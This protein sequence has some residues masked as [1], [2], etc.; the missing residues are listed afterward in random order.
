MAAVMGYT[1]LVTSWA[2]TAN[3]RLISGGSG[4]SPATFTLTPSAD[5][6]DSTVMAAS[7]LATSNLKGLRSWSAAI[8]AICPV[9]KIG[10]GASITFSPGY[11]A[12]CTTFD[13]SFSADSGDSTIM[14][15]SATTAGWKQNMPGLIS[16]EGSYEVLVDDTTALA[17]PAGSSEPATMTLTLATGLSF[18]GS[19][20][21][22]GGAITVNPRQRSTAKYAFK[23]S[24][25]VT[26][27]GTS[28]PFAAGSS[29]ALPAVGSIVLQAYTSRTFT[30]DCFW[31]QIKM[32]CPVGN[33][34][35]TSINA[36]GTGV[37]TPA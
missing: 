28:L 4:A 27:T 8:E 36:I 1:G 34:I 3:T 10:S 13:I 16:W 37:L 33:Q 2:G 25:N 11:V 23:G 29:I 22:T 12:N 6:F 31:N 24:G 14:G 19:V 18:A 5:A 32:S 15:A 21:T 7:L 9:P 26:V 30:G 17:M 20:F 35:T